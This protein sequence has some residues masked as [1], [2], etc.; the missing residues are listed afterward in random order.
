MDAL[1][2]GTLEYSYI[3]WGMW[4]QFQKFTTLPSTK[5]QQ[6]LPML[7]TGEENFEAF[8]GK[9]LLN[10]EVRVKMQPLI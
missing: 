6:A 7:P 8:K 10:L 2:M 9:D 4:L 1:H 5:G 3:F